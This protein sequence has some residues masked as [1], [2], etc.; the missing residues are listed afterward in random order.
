M[1]SAALNPERAALKGA[2][3]VS[4]SVICVKRQQH[5]ELYE[6]LKNECISSDFLRYL[7]VDQRRS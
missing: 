4:I 1:A 6:A 7:L 2:A 5:P 3:T